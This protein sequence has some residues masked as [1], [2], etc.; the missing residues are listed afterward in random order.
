LQLPPGTY[1]VTVEAKGSARFTDKSL[2]LTVGETA[3]LPVTL[4]ISTSETV[5]VSGLAEAIETQRTSSTNTINQQRIDNLPTNGRNYVNFALTD[6]QTT[7]DT[8]PS[9]GAAPTSGIN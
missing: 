7:R 8:A 2:P 4:S 9:I 1:T 6:S 5:E 3:L